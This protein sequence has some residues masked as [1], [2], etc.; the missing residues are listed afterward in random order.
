MLSG[1]VHN[2]WII[3]FRVPANPTA[4]AFAERRTFLFVGAMHGSDNPNADSMGISAVQSRR[5][6]AKR[7]APS[8]PS[9]G[10]EP[11]LLERL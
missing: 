11:T 6:S 9:L 7:R 5:L 4:A 8:W 3:G 1:G 10:T 2:V